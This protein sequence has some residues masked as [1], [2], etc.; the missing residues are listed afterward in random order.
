MV[1]LRDSADGLLTFSAHMSGI[2]KVGSTESWA[3]GKL[4]R[5]CHS[6]FSGFLEDSRC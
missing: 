6:A 1:T 3:V 4:L 2:G 5:P